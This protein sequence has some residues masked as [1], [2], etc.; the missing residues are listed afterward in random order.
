MTFES[1]QVLDLSRLQRW[2]YQYCRDY[3]AQRGVAPTFGEL[4]AVATYWRRNYLRDA[5]ARLVAKKYMRQGAHGALVALNPPHDRV[6]VD[7]CESLGL[8]L[9]EIRVPGKST[10]ILGRARRVL[11]KRLRSE[12][13]Y[14]ASAIGTIINRHWQTVE[15]YF[16]HEERMRRN[17]RRAAVLK[18]LRVAAS[19]EARS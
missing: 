19:N 2:V 8:S 7:A 3:V 4:R 6:I 5:V 17:A 15:E 14:S 13:G 10:A 12:L 9:E 11:A 16:K 1:G 18:S